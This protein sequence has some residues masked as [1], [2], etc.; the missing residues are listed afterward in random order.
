MLL[1]WATQQI[2]HSVA[3]CLIKHKFCLIQVS[4]SFE[5]RILDTICIPFPD[6]VA[7]F[8]SKAADVIIVSFQPSLLPKRKPLP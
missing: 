1:I 7:L 6:T 4:K 2:N 5:D 3:H 8:S